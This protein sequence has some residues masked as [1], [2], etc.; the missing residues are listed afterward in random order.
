QDLIVLSPG[1]TPNSP[2]MDEA[3]TFHIPI[4]GE[5]E[6]AALFLKTN[7]LSITGSNGK[8]TT[9]TLT[10]EIL[11]AGGLTTQIGGNIGLPAIEL[12]DMPENQPGAW[13]VLELSSFQLETI[14]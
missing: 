11:K 9:T 13:T 14:E 7:V 12:V 10:G 1:V 5:I 4:I 8:T 3:R 2:E 6:L